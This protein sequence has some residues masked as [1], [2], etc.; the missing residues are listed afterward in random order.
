ML[1]THYVPGTPNWL[2]LGST[3]IDAAVAFYTAVFDWTFR[4]AG[5]DAGG[6]G[7]FQKGGR[8][9]GAVGPLTEE[10]AGAAWTVYFHTSDAEATGRAVGQAG[11]TV[12]FPAMDV[13]TAGR[14][15]GFT[16]PAGA[17]FAVWEPG[18]VQGL[19]TVMEPDA[20]CWTELHT[21]DAAA[22]KAFYGA[23]FSWQYQDMPAG[24]GMVYTVVSAPGGGKGG[25]T[26]HGGVMQLP[27]ENREAGAVSEWHPYFG[28]DDCDTTF[29]AATGHGATALMPPS[30]VPGVG[31]LAMLRDPAGAVFALIKGDPTVR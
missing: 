23:V 4:S 14:M 22:A 28:V 7:Y 19:D 31:R 20:M 15:A 16:D 30:D 10:G 6:Y 24:D 2:D 21:T 26:G 8:T 25:D 1:T 11:G 13:F 18:D 17:E 29:A 27:E 12:R 9:V 3:D 5:P